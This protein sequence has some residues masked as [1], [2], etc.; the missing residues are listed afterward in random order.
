MLTLRK[1]W[2]PNWTLL[3]WKPLFLFNN[4]LYDA[5]NLFKFVEITLNRNKTIFYLF[6]FL[7]PFFTPVL[8]IVTGYGLDDRGV[9]VRFPVGSRI[10]S[11]QRR[12]NRLWSPPSLLSN[13]YRG[14]FPGGKEAGAW[15]WPL[16]LVSRPRNCGSIHPFPHTPLWHSAWLVKHKDKF[17][18]HG[19]LLADL[20]FLNFAA[21]DFKIRL[22]NIFSCWSTAVFRVMRLVWRSLPVR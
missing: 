1:K 16:R 13:G 2:R 21:W 19:T 18:L 20:V 10:F 22:L 12:P 14:F 9:G 3:L 15:R 6:V 11:S 8:S 5:T 4:F 17:T 7:F